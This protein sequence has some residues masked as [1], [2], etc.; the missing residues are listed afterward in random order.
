[1]AQRAGKTKIIPLK[2]PEK[3]PEKYL[4]KLWKK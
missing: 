4:T 2:A 1:M 3:K